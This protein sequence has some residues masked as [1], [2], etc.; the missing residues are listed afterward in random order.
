[1]DIQ[2]L[3]N[4]FI[5]MNSKVIVLERKQPDYDFEKDY[6]IEDQLSDTE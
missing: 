5:D 1:M 6:N 3:M 4:M 2:K